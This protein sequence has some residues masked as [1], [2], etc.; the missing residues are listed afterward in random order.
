M[1]AVSDAWI[2]PFFIS[3]SDSTA[4]PFFG[5]GTL[6][7]EVLGV[8]GGSYYQELD[9]VVGIKLILSPI[10]LALIHLYIVGKTHRKQLAASSPCFTMVEA[11]LTLATLSLPLLS[12]TKVRLWVF[13]KAGSSCLYRDCH[14]WIANLGI[15]WLQEY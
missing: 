10:I 4:K 5:P 11:I 9:I 14:F 12:T 7:H 2:Y 8:F 13:W 1:E 6:D 15:L 3:R